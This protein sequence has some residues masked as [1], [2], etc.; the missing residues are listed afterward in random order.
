LLSRQELR[1]AR[2]GP[3]GD[4]RHGAGKVGRDLSTLPHV[5]QEGA[6]GGDRKLRSAAARGLRVVD[7]ETVNIGRLQLAEL[8]VALPKPSGEQPSNDRLVVDQCRWG[9]ATLGTQEPTIIND[10][11]VDRGATDCRGW[12]R[13]ASEVTQVLQ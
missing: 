6:Q 7:D 1:Q 2:Q 12:H 11:L 10:D 3:T 5:A 9:E 4:R 8:H 13:K